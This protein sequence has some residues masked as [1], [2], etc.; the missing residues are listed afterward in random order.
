[1]QT[2][3]LKIITPEKIFF[4]GDVEQLTARTAVGNVGILAG[5]APYVANIIE[6]PLKIR[7][8]GEDDKLAAVSSGFIKADESSATVVVQTVEWAEDI[9]VKRAERA[10]DHAKKSMDNHNSQ[11]E[12]EDAERKL[13]RALNRI[14]VAGEK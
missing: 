14:G 4:E 13:K 3:K 2:F 8:V 7:A 10:R 9:D 11:K 6:S 12:F 1:M 5:H